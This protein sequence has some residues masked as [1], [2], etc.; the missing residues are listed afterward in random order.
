MVSKCFRPGVHRTWPRALVGVVW[1]CITVCD[2]QIPMVS[3]LPH[4]ENTIP[5]GPAPSLPAALLPLA[6]VFPR[7]LCSARFLS[8]TCRLTTCSPSA[9]G[10]AHAHV[11]PPVH[12]ASGSPAGKHGSLGSPPG[13]SSCFLGLVRGMVSAMCLP[14]CRWTLDHFKFF[15]LTPHSAHESARVCVRVCV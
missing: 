4:K 1:S 7:T 3:P 15:S 8:P 10:G 2:P 12:C 6:G 5:Q 9:V 14:S 13:A 11:R